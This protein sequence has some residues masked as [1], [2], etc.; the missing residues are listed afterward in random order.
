MRNP[1]VRMARYYPASRPRM[2]S[3]EL[4]SLVGTYLECEVA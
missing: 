3:E 2:Q 1:K 4:F